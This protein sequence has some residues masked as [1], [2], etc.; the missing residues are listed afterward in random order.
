MGAVAAHHIRGWVRDGPSYL[1]PPLGAGGWESV[2]VAVAWRAVR[3]RWPASSGAARVS[4]PARRP[5]V[6]RGTERVRNRAGP[7]S[8]RN[9]DEHDGHH[10]DERESQFV[11]LA[12]DACEFGGEYRPQ[13]ATSGD[14][15]R[16]KS[17]QV[18]KGDV[19]GSDNLL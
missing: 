11:R 3:T 14:R 10:R 12:H 18:H 17:T 9:L 6:S 5:C 13:F 2:L 16:S 19:V 4:G 15:A 7:S 1:T 8:D